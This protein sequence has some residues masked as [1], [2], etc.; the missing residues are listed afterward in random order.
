MPTKLLLSL[1]ILLASAGTGSAKPVPLQEA[2][3]IVLQAYDDQ[4]EARSIK[5]PV[6]SPRDRGALRWLLQAATKKIPANPFRK[7]SPDWREAESLCK[8]FTLPA[9]AWPQALQAQSLN[10]MGTKLAFWRWG[11]S[12]VRDGRLGPEPRR[13]WEDRLLTSGSSGLPFEY[14]LRHALC[15]ALAEADEARFAA[16]KEHWSEPAPD[17]FLDFQ[18][19]FALLGSPS[20]VFTFWKLPELTLLERALQ[21]LGSPRLWIAADPGRTLPDLPE[22]A[23]WI[24]PTKEGVQ[25]EGQND[26]VEPS[27]GEARDLSARLKA[28]GRSAFLAPSRKPFETYALMYFP[29]QV[30]LDAAGAITR[31]RMGD[32]ALAKPLFRNNSDTLTHP[33]HKEP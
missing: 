29:I 25:P 15:F 12:R 6:V 17:L 1:L 7:G 24:V 14:A 21:A 11:Q 4:Q 23:A 2:E 26:L 8:L 19:A 16:L 28:A 31:I 27:L 9:E 33:R 5:A 18:R 10:R 22:G 30:D 32:A 3:Q 13:L 20:P